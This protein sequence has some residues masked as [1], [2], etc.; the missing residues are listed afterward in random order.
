M[1]SYLFTQAVDNMSGHQSVFPLYNDLLNTLHVTSI[2][3]YAKHF[4]KTHSFQDR[5]MKGCDGNV[6]YVITRKEGFG[7]TK[8]GRKGIR[9]KGAA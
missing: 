3:L 4:Q 9:D 1:T 8:K 5:T 7:I 6:I 2:I